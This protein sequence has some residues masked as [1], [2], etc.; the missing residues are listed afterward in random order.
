MEWSVFL[1]D[2]HVCNSQHKWVEARWLK[3]W[4]QGQTGDVLAWGKVL[5]QTPVG[6]NLAAAD[7]LS[8]CGHWMAV[9]TRAPEKSNKLTF[10]NKDYR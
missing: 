5:H 7:S 1:S 8:C 3:T 10:D 4:M 9:S 6:I 2:D